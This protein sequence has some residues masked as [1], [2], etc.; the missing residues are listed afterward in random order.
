[1]WIVNGS[2]ADTASSVGSSNYLLGLGFTGGKNINAYISTGSSETYGTNSSFT[3]STNTDY[4]F[5][6]IRQGTTGTAIYEDTTCWTGSLNTKSWS[7]FRIG[8]MNATNS[9][10]TITLTNL[11]VKPL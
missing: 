7:T 5:E 3:V 11:K 2:L 10:H 9:S 6:L 1:M 8:L 4:H